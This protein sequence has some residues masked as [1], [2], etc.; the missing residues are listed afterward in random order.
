MNYFTSSENYFRNIVG[1]H[2]IVIQ[3]TVFRHE[4]VVAGVS[5][6]L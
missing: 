5:I 4:N 3:V 2:G 1:I 6:V